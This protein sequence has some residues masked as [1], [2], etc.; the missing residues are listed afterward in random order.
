MPLDTSES[1][2]PLNAYFNK[3]F[4]LEEPQVHSKLEQHDTKTSEMHQVSAND[5]PNDL[6]EEDEEEEQEQ[7]AV[8][9]SM[10]DQQ[11]Q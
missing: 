3:N 1:S 6:D 8:C 11:Q 5:L 10:N 2:H 9:Q 4:T 7:S